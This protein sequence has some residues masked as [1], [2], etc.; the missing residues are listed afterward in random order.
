M[1]WKA[2]LVSRM[3]PAKFPWAKPSRMLSNKNRYLASD[4]RSASS[5]CLRSV[6]SISTPSQTTW[7]FSRRRGAE[8]NKR[9][10]TSPAGIRRRTSTRKDIIVSRARVS[11]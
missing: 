5:A 9:Q 8:L 4:W 10:R 7:P 2:R 3:W 11:S 6:T 1:V